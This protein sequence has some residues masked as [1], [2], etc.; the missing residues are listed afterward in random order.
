MR[1]LRALLATLVLAAAVF[2]PALGGN[3]HA[4]A[5]EPEALVSIT[6]AS[7]D[8]ALPKRDGTITITGEV[9]NTSDKRLERPRAYFWRNQAPITDR[10]GFDAALESSSNE[11]LGARVIEN[12]SIENL[13]SHD[14]PYLEIGG[15]AAFTLK[16]KVADLDLSPTSGVYLMGVHVL[17]ND[18]PVAIGRSRLFV[19]ILAKA[20]RNSLQMTS[21]V[22]LSSRPSLLRPATPAGKAMFADDHLSKE[23]R[24]GG[25]L[26]T[27][28]K[29][30]GENNASFA[31]DPALVEEL[32]AM[33]GGYQVLDGAADGPGKSDAERWLDSFSR[34]LDSQDGYRLL[35]GSLDVAA[36]SHAGRTDVIQSSESA[37]KTVTLTAS[38]PLLIWPGSGAADGST[39]A[40]T[41]TAEPAAL[42]LSDSSTRATEPLLRSGAG[43]VVVNY[44]S[45]AYGGG[46]GPDPSDDSVHL[47]QRLL[48][49]SWIQAST[50]P[51]GATLGH[52][53]LISTAAQAESDD[54]AV[55]A[56]WFRQS[57]L[58]QLLRSTPTPWNGELRY[59]DSNRNKELSAAQLSELGALS[60]A[61]S[62]WQ[63]LL[64]DRTAAKANA[65]AA[66]AR[67]A[68]V[69]RRGTESAYAAFVAPQLSDL[70]SKLNAIVIS[71][72]RRVLTPKSGASFP[73]TIR[74]TLPPSGN[75]ATPNVNAV[76]VKLVFTSTNSQ[77]LTVQPIAL[78]D[79]I[80]AGDNIQAR[81]LVEAKT[82]GTVQVIAQLYTSSGAPVGEP[83]TIDV[84]A[85]EA[86]TVGWLIAIGAGIV[87]I[88]TTA[89]R[90][91]QVTRERARA[92]A[93][94]DRE[95]AANPAN[96]APLG[97]TRSAPAVDTRSPDQSESIDV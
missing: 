94:A 22:A 96:G 19:P 26:D 33:K 48:A 17:Q 97:A 76:R 47:Q 62:T 82:N 66:V 67:A 65:D 28:L 9:K 64:V 53:R 74:N 77:R 73:I 87:L 70:D 32:Q 75:P 58:T 11:P 14:K 20:P 89:L 6:L 45:T 79:P 41:A 31:V 3:T 39:L 5:A 84:Q 44:T 71:R 68:S 59:S 23:I 49:D 30:A 80:L 55:K 63:D 61:W 88:G 56:P 36:L 57:T 24:S 86:G 43:P 1:A 91:R 4:R 13:F 83:A 90:I 95:A 21:V 38:L 2:V 50:E 78:T 12:G 10:E 51:A 8:P 92:A 69:K 35:Y 15:Q 60:R 37:A 18:A 54:E 29:A 52:V 16:V 42:L 25:R 81:A 40:D 34:V 93:Q 85:T 7:F 27:L 46:P 72:N